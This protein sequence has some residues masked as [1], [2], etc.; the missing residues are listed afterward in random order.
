MIDDTANNAVPPSVEHAFKY[1]SPIPSRITKANVWAYAERQRKNV[2]LSNGFQL[3][4]LISRNG[5]DISYIDFMDQDQTDAIVV[6]P[7]GTFRIRL[8]S[9]TGALR[10]N[11]TI[12]HEL[13]HKLLH[14]PLV[15]KKHT[16]DG[17]RATR[18]VDD[19]NQDLVRCE[20][21]ANWFASA[22]LMPAD[23]F[24]TAYS[25]GVASETFGVTSAAVEVRAKTFGLIC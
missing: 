9:Q 22:F 4:K 17:M 8:S 16:G 7:D 6:E 25:N 18:R 23:E 5:G 2:G 14:W 15:K 11:F 21:E 10:D 19:S 3:P 24:K 1:R 13:G 12:A 20:W